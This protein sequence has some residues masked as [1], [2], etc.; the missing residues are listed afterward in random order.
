MGTMGLLSTA[1]YVLAM[2]TMGP[3][4]DNAGG[5][6]EMSHQPAAVRAVTDSLDAMGNVTKAVTKGYG[7]GSAGLASFLLFRAF[8][9]VIAEYSGEP[10][11]VI[12]FAEPAVFVGGLAGG[13]LVFLFSAWTM[14]AVGNTA[15]KVVVEVRRQFEDKPGIMD[16]SDTP[17]YA[18][19]V[20]IV[21]R[22]ALVEMIR[23]G[24]LAVLMPMA[25]GFSFRIGAAVVSNPTPL[26]GPQAVAG[27]LMVSTICGILMSLTLNNAGGAWDNAKKYIETGAFGGKNSEA[28]KASVTGDTVGDPFKDTSGPSLHV[29]IKLVATIALVMGPLFM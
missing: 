7:I 26:L 24:L 13:G 9:D 29:L 4:A 17:D 22:S 3:I 10:F 11:D 19:C 15:A 28:H 23:P 5:I 18:L 1:V 21:A 8:M 12:N 2:D 14:K 16:Y 20:A 6:V 27:F 25:V